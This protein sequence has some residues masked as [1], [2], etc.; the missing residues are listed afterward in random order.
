MWEDNHSKCPSSTVSLSPMQLVFHLHNAF[1]SIS[2]RFML[3]EKNIRIK[4]EPSARL[5]E[6]L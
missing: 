6:M 2:N 3:I 4:T 5:Q 1:T